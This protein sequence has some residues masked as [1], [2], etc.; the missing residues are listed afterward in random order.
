VANVEIHPVQYGAWS[1]ILDRPPSIACGKGII[2]TSSRP[3]DNFSCRSI[4][5][6]SIP[7]RPR[8]P[9]VDTWKFRAQ[10]LDWRVRGSCPHSGF[11]IRSDRSACD[12]AAFARTWMNGAHRPAPYRELKSGSGQERSLLWE[13]AKGGTPHLI[14]EFIVEDPTSLQG[15]GE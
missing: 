9:K 14:S 2:Q 1:A 12:D 10:D 13:D 5:V 3:G 6:G 4:K 7:R 15:P 11:R 8:K